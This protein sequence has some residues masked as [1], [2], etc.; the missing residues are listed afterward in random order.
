MKSINEY[1]NT[2]ISAKRYEMIKETINESNNLNKMDRDKIL[3]EA[4]KKCNQ[5]IK[6]SENKLGYSNYNTGV[7]IFFIKSLKEDEYFKED[8]DDFINGDSNEIRIGTWNI[9]DAD[10]IVKGKTVLDWNKNISAILN[11][12]ES[13]KEK[14]YY[15]DLD[16]GSS[17]EGD[18]LLVLR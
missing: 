8:Y 4:V 13:I 2:L 7:G 17:K 15:I 18:I 16:G 1:V 6:E 9:F 14:D 11:A 5:V 12:L 3:S 10:D